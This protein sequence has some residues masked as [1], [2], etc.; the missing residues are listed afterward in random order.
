MRKKWS[1]KINLDISRY[2]HINFLSTYLNYYILIAPK[3]VLIGKYEAERDVI[4]DSS[5]CRRLTTLLEIIWNALA[6]LF[7]LALAGF[8]SQFG[9]G[10]YVILFAI[11]CG[12]I[13]NVER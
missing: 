11:S 12:F 2:L 9:F 7:C 4:L 5:T 1:I 10:S 13:Y 8:A 3:T 6:L